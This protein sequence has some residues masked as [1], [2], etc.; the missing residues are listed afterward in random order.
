MIRHGQT[1]WSATGRH[2]STTDVPLTAAGEAA[3]AALAPALAAHEFAL[4]LASPR[5]R[6]RDTARLAG[7]PGA[8]VDPDLQEWN[9]G[10]CEGLTS[11]EICAQGPEL[12]DW[13]VWTG[14]LPG[15]E[16]LAEVGARARRVMARADA[17]AGDVLLFGHGHQ[18]R[19]LA[20]VALG[21]DPGVGAHFL[22]DPATVSVIGSEHGTRAI[23]VWNRS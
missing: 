21:L 5:T 12:R 9:Y 2:T 20:A 11:A 6:A 8:E 16:T 1:E 13:T 3:A 22:L 19:V 18:L 15:G 10:E 17:A 7:F 4:V 14:P 23:R